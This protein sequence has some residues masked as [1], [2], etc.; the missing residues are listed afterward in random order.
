M[1]GPSY[2]KTVHVDMI[3]QAS[4]WNLVLPIQRVKINYSGLMLCIIHN[5][6]LFPGCFNN[7]HGIDTSDYL[8]YKS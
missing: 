6:E 1:V 5:V 3:K 4:G 2:I 7:L 8:E